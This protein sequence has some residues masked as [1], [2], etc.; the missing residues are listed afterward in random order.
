MVEDD[1]NLLIAFPN[2]TESRKTWKYQFQTHE[3]AEDA[4][5]LLATKKASLADYNDKK[6][7]E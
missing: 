2:G 1:S 5:M 3:E 7:D 4:L 6:L